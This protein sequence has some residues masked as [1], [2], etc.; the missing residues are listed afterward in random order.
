MTR[1]NAI[2]E[3]KKIKRELLKM[4][5]KQIFKDTFLHVGR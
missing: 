3:I 4:R 1:Q 5:A 2:I